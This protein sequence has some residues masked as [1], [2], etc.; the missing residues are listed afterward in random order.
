MCYLC[1]DYLLLI[2][3]DEGN[4]TWYQMSLRAIIVFIIATIYVRIAGMRAFRKRSPI[5]LVTALILGAVLGKGITGEAPFIPVLVAA[6]VFVLM[7]KLFDQLLYIYRV[8]RKKSMYPVELMKDGMLQ[9]KNMKKMKLT[10][11]DLEEAAR[12]NGSV[13]DLKMVRC[14]YME[15]DGKI[16]IVHA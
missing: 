13:D 3:A 9:V 15:S 1:M 10:Y 11:E 16:S 14:I 2:G 4:L 5:D 7:H 8:K 6:L 12:E